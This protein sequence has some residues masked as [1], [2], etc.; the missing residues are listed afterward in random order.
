MY[1]SKKELDEEL[2]SEIAKFA[3][4]YKATDAANA[5]YG[6][7]EALLDLIVLD[8]GRLRDGG[9][10]SRQPILY[11]NQQ[12]MFVEKRDDGSYL[13]IITDSTDYVQCKYYIYP[14][15]VVEEKFAD[16]SYLVNTVYI[17]V[18]QSDDEEAFDIIYYQNP[19]EQQTDSEK[20][21]EGNIYMTNEPSIPT[22][23]FE[24]PDSWYIDI[25][26]EECESDYES[27][28]LKTSV[29][30]KLITI[31]QKWNSADIMGIS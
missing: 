20:S 3:G 16:D 1:L 19:E 10:A 14:Q 17:H 24:Y 28:I 7:G 25:D 21:N 22:M 6:E 11:P 27:V 9:I 13:C 15:G 18:F 31:L 23:M 8:D 30:Q 29:V 4:T 5:A 26:A 2:M 12:P